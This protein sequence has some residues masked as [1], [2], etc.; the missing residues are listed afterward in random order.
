MKASMESQVS[1]FYKEWIKR[2]L[3]EW[4]EEGRYSPSF[5]LSSE[6]DWEY[7]KQEQIGFVITYVAHM[8]IDGT[9]LLEIDFKI[10]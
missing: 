2:F 3:K 5:L 8:V 9:S 10:V 7:L 4:E 6:E 1:K